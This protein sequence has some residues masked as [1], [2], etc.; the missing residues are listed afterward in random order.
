MRTEMDIMHLDERQRLH[1]L[2][3]NRATLIVVGAVWLAMIAW[4]LLQDRTPWYLISM[5]PIFAAVRLGFYWFY[6]RDREVR[7]KERLVF[8][9][10]VGV[11]HWVAMVAAELGEF[12]TSGLFGLFPEPGHTAWKTAARILEFPAGTIGEAIGATDAPGYLW[13]TFLNSAL[14]AGAISL[15][16][17]AARRKTASAEGAELGVSG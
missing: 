15:I 4:E 9:V 2:K 5:V 7:W 16:V 8:F 14:W 11:G 3:A 6:A 12:S 13:L 1:W 10:L 17:W